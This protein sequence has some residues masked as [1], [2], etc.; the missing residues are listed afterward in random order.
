MLIDL[1]THTYPESDDSDLSPENLV[2]EARRVGL[3]G[4]CITNHD[5]FWP[6]ETLENLSKKL[7]FLI[8]PGC[9]V[10][11]DEGHLLVFGLHQYMFGMHR[12]SFVKRLVDEAEGFIVMAHPY[13]RRYREEEHRDERTGEYKSVYLQDRL[14]Q[15]YNAPV[16]SLVGAVETFNGRGSSHENNFS[17]EIG[18][19]FALPST[20]ASDAHRIEDI[21]TFATQFKNPIHGLEDLI[22]ELRHGQ[23]KPAVM[24]RRKSSDE[25]ALLN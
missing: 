1:H 10:N 8:I 5:R 2:E 16:F 4:I 15:A 18:R 9:E 19:H 22:H 20:G 24:E 25:V 12:A 13:R 7:D 23:Y 21:G 14:N 6:P 3:D 11:T 17:W